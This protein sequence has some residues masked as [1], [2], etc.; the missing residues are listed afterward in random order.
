MSKGKPSTVTRLKAA[1]PAVG[2]TEEE[3]ARSRQKSR[4]VMDTDSSYLT[5]GGSPHG[6]HGDPGRRR[7]RILAGY[8]LVTAAVAAVA[9]GFFVASSMPRPLPDQAAPAATQAATPEPA[10]ET[11]ESGS[12][13]IPPLPEITG[14]RMPTF[15]NHVVTG[16]NGNKAAVA[17]DPETDLHMGALAM[18]KLGLNSNGCFAGV[19]PDGTSTDGLIFPAGTTVTE[20]GVVFPDGVA[21]NIGEEFAFGGGSGDVD[22]GACSPS[23]WSFLVQSWKPV[24]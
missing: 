13:E 19:A 14:V 22:P 18:G 8:G 15:T 23:G 1:D 12:S 7:F 17:S 9:A 4:S 3:L 24:P 16:G 2:I 20:T 6:F 21:L 5:P 11:R 10:P